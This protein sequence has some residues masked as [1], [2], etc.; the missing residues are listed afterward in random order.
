METAG[1]R[2]DFM[3]ALMRCHESSWVIAAVPRMVTRLVHVGQF[4]IGREVWG[5]TTLLCPV[6]APEEWTDV[7]TGQTIR[8]RKSGENLV[9]DASAAFARLPVAL[10][11]AGKPGN[12]DVGR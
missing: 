2:R 3:C 9:I 10:L 8:A 1:E 11:H 5:D 4:P 6:G 7:L 12:R